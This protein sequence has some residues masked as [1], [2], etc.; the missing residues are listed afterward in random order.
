MHKENEKINLGIFLWIFSN[1]R[2]RASYKSIIEDIIAD[3]LTGIS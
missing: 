1:K 3:M 2:T